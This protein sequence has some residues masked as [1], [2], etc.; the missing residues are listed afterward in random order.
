MLKAISVLLL[1]ISFALALPAQADQASLR[2]N[3]T[4]ARE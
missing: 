2:N 4:E 3:L 1:G